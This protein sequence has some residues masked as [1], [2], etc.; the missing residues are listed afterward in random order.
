MPIVS[1]P[2]QFDCP[3]CFAFA[4]QQILLAKGG[5]LPTSEDFARFAGR[6]FAA[7]W[8]TERG[9]SFSYSAMSLA[10]DDAPHGFHFTPLRQYLFEHPDV[11]HLAARAAS[12]LAWKESFRFCPACGERLVDDDEQTA[13]RCPRCNRQHF[14]RIEPATITLVSRGEEILLVKN[15]NASRKYFACVSGFVEAGESAE[16]CVVREV[17]EET[18]LTVKNVRYVASQAWPFPDQLMLAFRADWENGQIAIQQQEII[19][20]AWFRRDKLPP[21]DQLPREGSV[22]WRLVNNKFDGAS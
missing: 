21:P 19:E 10:G 17:K 18:G 4:G 15:R 22:A 16:Q 12:L 8:Y 3:L 14:P 7:H 1:K 11:A 5:T 20:A 2:H 6:G 13:A 9:T